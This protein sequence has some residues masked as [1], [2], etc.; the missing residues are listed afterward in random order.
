ML[1]VIKVLPTD[2]PKQEKRTQTL[3]FEM[4]GHVVAVQNGTF[5]T[6]RFAGGCLVLGALPR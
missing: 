4:T 2:I 5:G 1:W 6:I 3:A